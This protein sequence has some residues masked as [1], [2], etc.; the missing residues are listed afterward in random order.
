[1]SG[2]AHH[3]KV[4]RST[5][6]EG[7]VQ[8]TPC[9]GYASP[10]PLCFGH[11]VKLLYEHAMYPLACTCTIKA[12]RSLPHQTYHQLILV[13][14]AIHVWYNVL[15][16]LGFATVSLKASRVSQE[17]KRRLP[18]AVHPSSHDE[19]KKFTNS[20]TR[21]SFMAFHVILVCLPRPPDSG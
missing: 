20:E 14:V 16:I 18:D 9:E 12:M 5:P 19:E 21:N 1:M 13:H 8:H 3:V 6:C 2:G 10:A 7:L 15:N 11:M 17:S 4:W